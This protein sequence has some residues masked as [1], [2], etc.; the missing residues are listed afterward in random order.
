MMCFDLTTWDKIVLFF[1]I[2]VKAWLRSILDFIY[3]AWWPFSMRIFLW[4][5]NLGNILSAEVKRE[6]LNAAPRGDVLVIKG[7]PGSGKTLAMSII[8]CKFLYEMS[9]IKDSYVGISPIRK[10]VIIP[11]VSKSCLLSMRLMLYPIN[12]ML[13]KSCRF[14]KN[15]DYLGS[16]K[17]LVVVDKKIELCASSNFS[18][19]LLAVEAVAA[20]F[21]AS[22]KSVGSDK[23]VE[24]LN[25]IFYSLRSRFR[26]KSL[27]CKFRFPWKIIVMLEDGGPLSIDWTPAN[28]DLILR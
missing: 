7:S 22:V 1:K 8:L 21:D 15:V 26:S 10:R 19:S 9:K 2:E 11:L 6:I 23:N 17:G 12:E 18:D 25:K 4:R 16:N 28:V 20:V 14:F 3:L 5:L 27:V 13:K 24:T